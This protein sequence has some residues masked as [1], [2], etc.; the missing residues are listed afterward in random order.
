MPLFHCESCVE[1]P[2]ASCRIE[3]RGYSRPVENLDPKK[4]MR[5]DELMTKNTE[6]ALSIA[7]RRELVALVRCAEK[8]M[9]E[10]ARALAAATHAGRRRQ[11]RHV[12]G[13]KAAA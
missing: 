12:T 2:I 11:R 9:L 8:L 4:Q 10:N 7:E 3:Q 5:L 1:L 6:G 13:H